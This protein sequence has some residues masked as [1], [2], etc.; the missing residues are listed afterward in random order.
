MGQFLPIVALAAVA[1]LFAGLS[2]I[3]SG[4][5]NARRPSKAKVMP[6]ECGIDDLTEPPRRFPVR[7]YLIAMI[8]IVFDIEIVFLYPFAMVFRG[9]GVYGL[10]AVAIFAFAVLESFLYLIANGALDWGPA[11]H[12]RRS[13][14][15][16]PHRTAATTVQR[17]GLEGRDAEERELAE[18]TVV[19]EREG[20]EAA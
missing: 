15:V 7:F 6:Y 19:A 5:L 9:L 14:L 18:A 3:A 16:S 12:V 13:E 17:V 8:F 11:K 4:L 2:F 10:I 1:A 20:H